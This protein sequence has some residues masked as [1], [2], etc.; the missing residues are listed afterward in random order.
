M[1]WL[2][3]LEA[4]T[5]KILKNCYPTDALVNG[6]KPG[7]HLFFLKH[8]TWSVMPS[9]FFT[10]T[11]NEFVISLFFIVLSSICLWM[12]NIFF[13]RLQSFSSMVVQQLVVILVCLWEEVSSRSFYSAILS[14]HFSP[15][16]LS[17][18]PQRIFSV[19]YWVSKG[20][21]F[22]INLQFLLSN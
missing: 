12:W 20:F 14:S 22:P 16:S 15:L 10:W 21:F 18:S 4:F 8:G 3:F 19:L 7:C 5:H 9:W 1:N 11:C 17:L 2:C 13:G 6:E